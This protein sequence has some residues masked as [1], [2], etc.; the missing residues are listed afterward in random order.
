M[1]IITKRYWKISITPFNGV[2]Y[3]LSKSSAEDN[4]LY[5]KFK[6]I[7]KARFDGEWT[8]MTTEDKDT[9]LVEWS[10][11][12][13]NTTSSCITHHHKLEV[14]LRTQRRPLTLT[15]DCGE[16]IILPILLEIHV[17][18][19][20]NTKDSVSNFVIQYYDQRYCLMCFV[21]VLKVLANTRQQVAILSERGMIIYLN[22]YT[23]G[24]ILLEGMI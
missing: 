20:P 12:M 24:V 9:V 11:N 21:N 19:Y 1:H 6:Y 17:P 5:E 16:C 4:D 22:H 2:C 10:V 13:R 3:S 8:D 18:L 7:T 14:I 23:N 15:E